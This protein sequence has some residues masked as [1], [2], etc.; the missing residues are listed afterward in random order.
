MN[1]P[2]YRDVI[3]PAE[4]AN[5]RYN[6]SSTESEVGGHCKTSVKSKLISSIQPASYELEP[7]VD[8][9][10]LKS[11]PDFTW[12]SITVFEVVESGIIKPR[13]TLRTGKV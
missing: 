5:S 11:L 6:A 4:T 9:S 8:S 7:K 3:R 10:R 2:Q 12:A 13:Y 1:L